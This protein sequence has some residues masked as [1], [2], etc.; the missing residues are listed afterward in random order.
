[1]TIVDGQ[2]EP[3]K[4]LK[5]TL[6]KS[7][8]SRFNSIGEINR[9]LKE[10]E[11]EKNQLPS[12]IEDAF[13]EEIQGKQSTLIAH[14]QSYD[15]LRAEIRNE[16][17]QK[18]R[19]L[20]VET[21]QVSDKSNRNLF[22]RAFYYFK[23]KSLSR[24]KTSLEN[25]LDSILKKKTSGAK[26]TVVQ[27]QNE[28][29]D[30]LKNKEAII[31][32]RCKKSLDD[33]IYTKEVIDGLYPVIAGAIG[34]S[35]VVRELQQ[36]PDDCYLIN[37]FSLKFDTPIYNKKENDRIFSI[38]IDHL[39]I[40]RAGVFLLETKN[41]NKAS[42]NSLDLRSPVKQISRTSFALF[43]LL[44]SD[45]KRNDIKLVRHHWGDKKIPIRNIIVMTNE[46]PKEEFKHVKILSLNELIG[47]IQYFDQMFNGEEAKGI[48]EYLKK[49]M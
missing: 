10:Y 47:Y 11:A 1:M 5:E 29:D 24:Q 16:L 40:S 12:R 32:G 20:D 31:S 41:W 39:L 42:V 23:I 2:I 49:R 34:E 13:D 18:I 46:K 27:L 43:V 33:L 25:N 7:G 30:S 26:N 8:V 9:F 48:Y 14:Q 4:K 44:N 36:L 21:K 19:N 37:D 28:I 15:E 6:N 38:Q 22:F 3:L 45:S 35:S 17:N